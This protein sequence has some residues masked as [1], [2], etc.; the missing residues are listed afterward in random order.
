MKELEIEI[1][2]EELNDV[3]AKLDVQNTM[4]V[5]KL[6]FILSCLDIEKIIHSN[7]IKKFYELL[8]GSIEK[9]L[10]FS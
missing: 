10:Q 8:T 6:D 9:T 1:E 4:S 3:F 7:I 5:G 2:D